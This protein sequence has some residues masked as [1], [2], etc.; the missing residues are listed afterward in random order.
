M[1]RVCRNDRRLIA[2]LR[3]IPTATGSTLASGH[4]RAI[5]PKLN[6][7]F[8]KALV[9]K[10][11]KNVEEI[12]GATSGGALDILRWSM[13]VFQTSVSNAAYWPLSRHHPAVPMGT[14]VYRGCRFPRESA[15]V[16][17]GG[18]CLS[19]QCRNHLEPQN[20]LTCSDLRFFR[21]PNNFQSFRLSLRRK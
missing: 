16:P 3:P 17:G 14:R 12:I 15:S 19:M 11:R 9:Q 5:L 20:G 18:V 10:R 6:I 8:T 21:P 13:A 2:S 1:E 7:K 4:S